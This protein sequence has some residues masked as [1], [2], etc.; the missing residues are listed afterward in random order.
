MKIVTSIYLN[1]RQDLRDDWLM[2]GEPEIEADEA[3]VS[4]VF[5]NS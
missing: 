3:Q 2:A 4:L 1:C 5:F